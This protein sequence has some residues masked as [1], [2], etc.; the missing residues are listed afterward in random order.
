MDESGIALCSRI[1]LFFLHKSMLSEINAEKNMH[2]DFGA[3]FMS[4]FYTSVFGWSSDWVM[5]S[6][7]FVWLSSI[8]WYVL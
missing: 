4:F 6:Q 8:I 3:I 7:M 1:L 5:L 2:V